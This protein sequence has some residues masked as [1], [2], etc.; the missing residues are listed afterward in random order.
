VSVLLHEDRNWTLGS[1]DDIVGKP[2]CNSCAV[3][4]RLSPGEYEDRP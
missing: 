3:V 4:R 1:K 2:P